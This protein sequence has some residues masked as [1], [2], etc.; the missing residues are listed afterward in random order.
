MAEGICKVY[1]RILFVYIFTEN[2]LQW[3]VERTLEKDRKCS[4]LMFMRF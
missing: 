4:K 1:H 2:I 3:N